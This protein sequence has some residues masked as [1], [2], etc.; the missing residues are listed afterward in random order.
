[1]CPAKAVWFTWSNWQRSGV[2]VESSIVSCQWMQKYFT[3]SSKTGCG[4]AQITQHE[5]EGVDI[6]K[7]HWAPLPHNMGINVWKTFT[8]DTSIQFYLD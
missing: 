2:T 5:S 3:C 6:S 1:L 4:P 7:K 8:R